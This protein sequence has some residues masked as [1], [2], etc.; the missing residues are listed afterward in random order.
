MKVKIIPQANKI[1]KKLKMKHKLIHQ[2]Q[3]YRINNLSYKTKQ[4]NLKNELLF[5]IIHNFLLI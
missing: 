2:V 4:V 5:I 1:I 3:I